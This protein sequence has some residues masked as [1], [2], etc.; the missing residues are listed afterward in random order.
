[1][2][3]KPGDDLLDLRAS[4]LVKSVLDGAQCT[5][6]RAPTPDSNQLDFKIRNIDWVACKDFTISVGKTQI[7]QYMSTWEVEPRWLFSVQFLQ[8]NE[9]EF[10]KQFHYRALWS[11]PSRRCPVPHSTASVYFTF[12][13][14]ST[15]PSTMPVRVRFQV[16]SSETVHT[17]GKTRFREKWLKDVIESKALLMD[18]ITF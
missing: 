1:M 16:E 14:S 6:T 3:T 2:D 4:E 7:E 18:T 17:P 13:T 12:S 8:E 10:E 9:L 15:K 5:L 11:M